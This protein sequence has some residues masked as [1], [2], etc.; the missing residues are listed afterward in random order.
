VTTA[1]AQPRRRQPPDVRREQ[2]LD[3]AEE[4]LLER[5]LAA[6]TMADVAAAADV[7]KGTVYLYFESKT[8]LL[9]GLR[10]RYLERFATALDGGVSAGGRARLP[11]AARIEK[12]VAASF[13]FALAHHRLHH[14]LLH[15]AGFSE[16]DVFARARSAI[17]TLIEAGVAGG[18]ID[19]PDPALATDFILSGLHGTLVTAIHRPHSARDRRRLVDGASELILRALGTRG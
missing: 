19:V 16:R 2:L 9:A 11:Y 7:A 8:E 1:Q 6:A 17:A 12:L 15:Q 4:V 3:A 13:D 10:A 18:E 14:L 5:G